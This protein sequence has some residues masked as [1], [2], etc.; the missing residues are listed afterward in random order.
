MPRSQ[1][2]QVPPYHFP[3]QSRQAIITVNGR[4]VLPRGVNDHCLQRL[5]ST[6]YRMLDAW[7]ILS[8]ATVSVPTRGR[9]RA[10]GVL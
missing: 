9:Q 1:P 8:E 10:R 4:D 6:R 3:K 5:Q 2:N 7:T